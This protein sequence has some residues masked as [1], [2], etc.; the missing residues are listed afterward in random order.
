MSTYSGYWNNIP[1][2]YD[3]AT[4]L[5]V[6]TVNAFNTIPS[7]PTV[8][9][10]YTGFIKP[11]VTGTWNFKLESD[12]SSALWIGPNATTGYTIAN[13]VVHDRFDFAFTPTSGSILLQKDI[14][15]PIRFMWGNLFTGPGRMN[16]SF[17]KPSAPNT[18]LTSIEGLT[19]V[20][21]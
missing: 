20:N 6:K 17:T 16:V 19:Y 14:I 4:P 13:A 3:T 12:D 21:S 10:I 2:A 8:T 15:Y 7:F 11:D 1:T 9:I 5:E 18:W